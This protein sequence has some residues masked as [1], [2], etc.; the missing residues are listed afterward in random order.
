M[1]RVDDRERRRMLKEQRLSGGAL[2]E[3]VQG[4][5][6]GDTQNTAVLDRHAERERRKSAKKERE[7]VHRDTLESARV[8][9]TRVEE[10]ARRSTARDTELRRTDATAAPFNA[11]MSFAPTATMAPERAARRSSGGRGT[12]SSGT[13]ALKARWPDFESYWQDVGRER[14]R[15]M[16][17]DFWWSPPPFRMPRLRLF[18]RPWDK[19]KWERARNGPM[20]EDMSTTEKKQN[21]ETEVEKEQRERKHQLE[22]RALK[23]TNLCRLYGFQV[24]FCFLWALGAMYIYAHFRMQFWRFLCW[25]TFCF[26][27]LIFA[28]FWIKAVFQLRNIIFL[29][30]RETMEH[31][32]ECGE[33]VIV[34]IRRQLFSRVFGMY[35][36]DEAQQSRILK[37]Q[38]AMTVYSPALFEDVE[39]V[40]DFGYNYR[41]IRDEKGGRACSVDSGRT[42][43][44][45]PDRQL[46]L[47]MCVDVDGKAVS[48]LMSED[49]WF[50]KLEFRLKREGPLVPDYPVYLGSFVFGDEIRFAITMAIFPVVSFTWIPY[51]CRSTLPSCW[52]CPSSLL[53][54]PSCAAI[55]C[56][57]TRP[58][59]FA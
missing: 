15:L 42:S 59:T 39:F 1:D 37:D 31:V 21:M 12:V 53:A 55:F 41:F 33:V 23:E 46:G 3:E 19:K 14:L 26:F 35:V 54:H 8:D 17:K 25:F 38:S 51:S 47:E 40:D 4:L 44:V 13:S 7:I 11:L 50:A 34:N 6:E 29:W 49:V 36:C 30:L 32:E 2:R 16:K 57:C 45:P 56:S 27:Q 18:R 48:Q 52:G 9:E 20:P 24:V 5:L 28:N 22:Q 10:K 43:K 58:S